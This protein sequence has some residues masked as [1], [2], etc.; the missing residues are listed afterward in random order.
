M[1][2]VGTIAGVLAQSSGLLADALDM[3][4][5]ASAYAI[6]ILAIGRSR[7][8]KRRAA[9][10]SGTLL[11]FLGTG[12]IVDAVRRLLTE[13]APEGWVMFA[14]AALSLATNA[15]VLRL[16]RRYREGEV[17]LRASWIFTRAGVIANVGVM[18]AGILV[19]LTGS[20]VPDLIIGCLVGLYVVREALE[21]LRET[22]AQ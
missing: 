10:A 19:L 5:D 11:L 14:V 4:A 22:R 21:I 15:T 17:H 6:A 3:L 16:L 7:M 18:F 12:V 8:F 2:M 20:R 13:S 9:L 1:F